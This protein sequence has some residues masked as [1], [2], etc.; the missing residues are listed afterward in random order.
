MTAT[1]RLFIAI[2]LPQPAITALT[3][4]QKQL[5]DTPSIR[6]VKPTQM[7]LTLQFLGDVKVTEL[8]RLIAAMNRTIP[9]NPAF[10]LNI[11]GLGAFPNIKRPRVIW[12]GVKGELKQL[13]RLY[14]STVDATQTIGIQPE[15][16]PFNAHLTL[17][18]ANQKVRSQDYKQISEVLTRYQLQ[19]GRLAT[20]SVEQ[21]SLIRSQ[22]KPGGPTYTNLAEI[23]LGSTCLST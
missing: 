18:R 16:R 20:I 14:Q 10:S 12:A 6:W 11:D 15:N 23:K 21:V 2:E 13:T 17:G 3:T 4:L 8:D 9:Q 1:Y 5:R 22:L 19:I 7:H